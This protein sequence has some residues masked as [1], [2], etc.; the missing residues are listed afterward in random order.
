MYWCC[1]S[2]QINSKLYFKSFHVPI[3]LTVHS[4]LLNVAF[5]RA[6]PTSYHMPTNRL[7]I[8]LHIGPNLHTIAKSVSLL[9]ETRALLDV[10]DTATAMDTWT[11]M[12][13]SIDVWHLGYIW[14]NGV[15]LAESIEMNTIRAC[16]ILDN[17][18]RGH[19]LECRAQRLPLL[20]KHR[21]RL[22]NIGC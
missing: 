8:H 14:K 6:R 2:V 20:R 22:C 17:E 13:L 19:S 16:G 18:S 3:Y 5:Y 12:R 15:V 4:L 21:Y 9:F 1:W 10:D 7:R 11:R